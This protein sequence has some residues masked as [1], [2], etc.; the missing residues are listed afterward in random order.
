M[1]PV[2]LFTRLF[3]KST[4]L[5]CDSSDQALIFPSFL[6]SNYFF[7]VDDDAGATRYASGPAPILPDIEVV[8]RGTVVA[9]AHKL[10]TPEQDCPE[11]L[12]AAPKDQLPQPER[13]AF[14]PPPRGEGKSL[15]LLF[16]VSSLVY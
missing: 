15:L 7:L 11:W 16:F 5:P 13:L 6:P 9:V 14:T 3:S 10:G 2:S 8:K 12:I 1:F 4:L